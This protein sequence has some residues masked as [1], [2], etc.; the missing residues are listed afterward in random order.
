MTRVR[1]MSTPLLLLV[2]D[3]PELGVIVTALGKRAGCEVVVR[4]DVAGGLELMAQCRPALVL[5]DINLGGQSGLDLCR[6]ARASAELASIP[7]ALFSQPGL[8][9]DVAAGLEAGADF[10]FSK[11]LVCRP[12]EWQRRLQEILSARNGQPAPWSLGWAAEQP[13][14]P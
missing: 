3:A 2:D 4:K 1:L 9:G 6:R 14:P 7:L 13:A 5:L 10:L 11:D 8:P 12:R